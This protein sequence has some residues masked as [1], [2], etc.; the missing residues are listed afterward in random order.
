MIKIS[1]PNCKKCSCSAKSNKIKYCGCNIRVTQDGSNELD[2]NDYI[3]S[4]KELDVPDGDES[5]HLSKQEIKS[6]RGKIGELL[7]ISLMTRPDLSFDVNAL[8]TEVAKGTIATAKAIN[9]VVKKAKGCKNVLRFTKLGNISEISVKVYADA[10]YG[11][12]GDKIRSTAGRVVLLENKTSG[13]VS[14][15]SWKTKRIARVCRSVKSAE[16]RALE[17]AID[18]GVNIARL[19]TEIYTGKVDLKKPGQ[20]P[21]EALTDS[22]SLWESLHNTRQCE[23][24]LLRNSI[25]GI[26]E[27]MDLKMVKNV[28]WVPT[29]KQ[30]SDCMKKRGKN[31]DW[32]L[33]VASTNSMA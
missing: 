33:K 18:D 8:S 9:G 14:V 17:E 1:Q 2:Q 27:L 21:V 30:L 26:K 16:T 31:S 6:V 32:L 11:N 28:T 5:D 24:K 25:A 3:E 12:Q 20:I 29:F 4:L 19:I 22:K 13:M 10:S 23:E 15:A 7:W